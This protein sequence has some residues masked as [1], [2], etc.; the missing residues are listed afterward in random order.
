MLINNWYVAAE[1]AD[2]VAGQPYGVRM[3]GCDFVLQRHDD[4]TVSCLSDV[5]IHRGASLARGKCRDGRV[6]C[7]FHGWEFD[8][9]GACVHIPSMGDEFAIPKRGKVD[10]YPV[11]ERYDWIWVFLG[12]LPEEKRPP[13]PELLPE[14]PHTEEWRTTR[15]ISDAPVNWQ[16]FEENS[17]DT[18][19]LAFV[20][21]TFGSRMNPKAVQ[22]PIERTAYGCRVQRERK[23]PAPSQK[24]GVLGALLS[25]PRE[26]TSVELEFSVVGAC[27]RIKPTFRPG[28]SQVTFS[29]TTPVDVRTCRQFGLQARNYAIEPEHDQERLDGRRNAINEDLAVVTHV[30][31]VRGPT[32]PR[33]EMLVRADEMETAF[34]LIVF[35]MIEAGW[36]IDSDKVEAEY[37]RK[38]YVI[39]SPARRLDPKGWVHEAVPTT[40]P[41]GEDDFWDQLK[42]EA[43]QMAPE[44]AE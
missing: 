12:D 5:C 13:L 31:P 15:M 19:H 2:V 6:I 16:K 38:V 34:R 39:P 36:E 10:S 3:L 37:E 20:H 1:S 18:A 23:A 32:P 9:T 35:R 22:A 17:L 24:T 7:P 25:E 30:R 27:H 26:K 28:M 29:A 14:Y 44:A 4:G 11:A 41:R 8:R 40:R 21:T 42:A 33:D 43:G